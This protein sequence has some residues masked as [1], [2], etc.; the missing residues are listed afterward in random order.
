[1]RK[2]SQT[3]INNQILPV[4]TSMETM[5]KTV[6]ELT[7]SDMKGITFQIIPQLY[8]RYEWSFNE[9]M[10]HRVGKLNPT[11]SA[12][13]LYDML[14]NVWELVRD[15]WSDGISSLTSKANPIVS[16]GNSGKVIRGG[17]FN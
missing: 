12:Y 7:D 11:S 9:F 1:M 14:G 6:H 8:W 10:I 3:T 4:Y 5:N 2:I 17:A 13:S 16:N 15:D